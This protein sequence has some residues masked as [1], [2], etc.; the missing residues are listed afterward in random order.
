MPTELADVLLREGR[1]LASREDT[2]AVRAARRGAAAAEG[3]GEAD[4]AF[5]TGVLAG[6]VLRLRELEESTVSAAAGGVHRTRRFCHC[7][8]AELEVETLETD[9]RRPHAENRRRGRRTPWRGG[10]STERGCS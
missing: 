3:G 10:T 4:S 1:E 7:K 8:E 9:L 2:E 5:T 6:M